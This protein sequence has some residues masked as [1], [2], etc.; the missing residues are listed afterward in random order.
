M[1]HEA[2][3][4]AGVGAEIV[5]RVSEKLFYQLKCPAQR[6]TGFDTIMPYYRNEDLYLM[7]TEQVCQTVRTMM[8]TGS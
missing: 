2:C 4:T 6:L 1:V 3:K 8:E 7:D 5:A